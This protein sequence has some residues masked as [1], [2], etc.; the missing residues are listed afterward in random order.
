[1]YNGSLKSA[2]RV[3]LSNIPGWRT[4]RKIVVIESDDW[5]SIRMSSLRAFDNLKTGGLPVDQSHYNIY[6]SLECDRDLECLYETLSKFK[7]KTGRHPGMTGVNVVA[8][9]DFEKI[10]EHDFTE[11]FYEPYTETLKHY[12]EHANVYNLWKQGISKRYFVPVMHGREHL[13]VQFWMRALQRRNKYLMLGFENG[14]TGIPTRSVNGDIVPGVQAAFNIETVNDISYLKDVIKSAS[15]LFEKLYGYR[16]RYFVPT[17]GY[18]NNVLEKDLYEVNVKYINTAK[19][20]EEPLGN[21]QYQINTRFLGHRNVLGQIYLTRNCFFEPAATGFEV[22]ASYDWLDYCL[23]E[24]E[25]AFKWHKPAIISSHR[26]N[27]VGFLHP[28]N[29]DVGLRMLSELLSR[30]LKRWPDIEF[31]TSVELGDL[32]CENHEK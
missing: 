4:K 27:Y 25:I 14:V 6:D 18:F 7:D 23:K 5:G 11:Y 9:P 28:E 3:T 19:K 15:E 17:N 8:N 31:M 22:S 10:R 24:I 32:I 12:P 20:Q 16:P 30:M 21:G 13:N 2:V 1:M 29:R 26:V